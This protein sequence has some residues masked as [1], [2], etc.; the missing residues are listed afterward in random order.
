M[1]QFHLKIKE[2]IFGSVLPFLL[3]LYPNSG[4]Q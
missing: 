3:P 2:I 4:A 1:F